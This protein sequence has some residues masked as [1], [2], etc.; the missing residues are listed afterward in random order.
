M[1][2]P[3][4]EAKVDAEQVRLCIEEIKSS[5]QFRNAAQLCKFL[6]YIVEAAL[7]G[8]PEDLKGAVLAEQ[9]FPNAKEKEVT[10]RTTASRLR[11]KL[12]EYYQNG[13]EQGQSYR[14]RLPP[15]SYLPVFEPP[16]PSQPPLPTPT[17]PSGIWL[18]G[19]LAVVVLL[20]VSGLLWKLW[21]RE[22][23]PET[24]A[25]VLD[26][27]VAVDGME[28][29]Y[30]SVVRGRVVQPD[31]QMYLLVLDSGG[32]KYY[33]QRNAKGHAPLTPCQDGLW[34]RQVWPG[35]DESG[36]QETFTLVLVEAE[37]LPIE[38]TKERLPENS[39][40]KALR[41]KRVPP[42]TKQNYISKCD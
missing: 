17:H 1:N 34:E 12:D 11:D 41:V 27:D 13:G 42:L 2:A 8:K 25:Y 7:S 40:R 26:F 14:V 9:L 5:P 31:R 33:V 3:E 4:V 22:D 19:V 10:V 35:T 37:Q 39:V 28:V 30:G 32:W 15:G 21:R 38:F 6:D 20:A 23:A 29:H 36:D 16:P 18:R 24:P